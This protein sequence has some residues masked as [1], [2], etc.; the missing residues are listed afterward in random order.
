M[1]VKFTENT[2][3]H[4]PHDPQLWLKDDATNKPNRNQVY[5]MHMISTWEK[6]GESYYFNNRHTTFR[7][8]PNI[9]GCWCA[10]PKKG[11]CTT[12][13]IFSQF[14]GKKI[15]AWFK[16]GNRMY[17]ESIRTYMALHLPPPLNLLV[18]DLFFPLHLYLHL[19]SHIFR[20]LYVL[21]KTYLYMEYLDEW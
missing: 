11:S 15:R 3:T 8:K 9:I 1:T 5:G 16:Q 13:S 12:G 18:Q 19:Y 10:N 4:P 7:P 6:K 14:G 21:F 17:W 2:S 20:N